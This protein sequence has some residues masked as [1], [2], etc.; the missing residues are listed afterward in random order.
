MPL[1]VASMK[2]EDGKP[3]GFV[4]TG[5]VTTDKLEKGF[6]GTGFVFRPDS[7]DANAFLNYMARNGYRHHVAFVQGDWQD[8]VVEALVNYL[9]Y[10]IDC[11]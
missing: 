9:E 1:T 4:T 6:F 3:Q 2:T 11:V 5:K 8:A 10:F 7:G